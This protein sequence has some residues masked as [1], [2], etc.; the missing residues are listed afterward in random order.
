MHQVN[1][2]HL[3]YVRMP[4][5]FNVISLGVLADIDTAEGNTTA[6]NAAALVGLTFGDATSP[7]VD[8]FVTLSEGSVPFDSDG[9]TFYD[10][11]DPTPE[12]FSIDGGADQGFDGTSV[13]SAT[14]TYTDGT[15]ATISAVSSTSVRFFFSP[16][17]SSAIRF[18]SRKSL[19]QT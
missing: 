13:Y 18:M 8:S 14:I 16:A 6:E 19:Q 7:L 9:N 4:T 2:W 5:T 17:S 12:T 15:T 11:N 10:M 3:V 1:P